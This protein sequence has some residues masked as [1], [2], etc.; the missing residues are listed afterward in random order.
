[1]TLKKI[2]EKLYELNDKVPT[3]YMEYMLAEQKYAIKRAKL[4]QEVAGQ[5]PSQPLR[6]AAVTM[7]LSESEE[8]E[9]FLTTSYEKNILDLQ[10]KINMQISRILL[11]QQ[12]EGGQNG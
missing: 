10:I 7:A 2:A 4:M 8:N 12:W 3:V 5:Y 1:M 11:G 6:D 9:K